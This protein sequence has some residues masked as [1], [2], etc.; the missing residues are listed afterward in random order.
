MPDVAIQRVLNGLL[1][2]ARN[3]K[4]LPLEIFT[5]TIFHFPLSIFHSKSTLIRH[6]VTPSPIKGEGTLKYIYPVQL[7]SNY[8]AHSTEKKGNS[9]NIFTPVAQFFRKT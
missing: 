3:D 2:Y 1:R 4:Q 8:V 5:V 6:S 7:N 9:Q